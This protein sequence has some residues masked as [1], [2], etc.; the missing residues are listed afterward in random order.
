[1]QCTHMRNQGSSTH[2]SVLICSVDYLKDNTIKSHGIAGFFNSPHL[3]KSKLLF[4][5]DVN[6]HNSITWPS[7]I[8]SNSSHHLTE[9]CGNRLLICHWRQASNIHSPSMPSSL[10]SH[11]L[12][13]HVGKATKLCTTKGE[14]PWKDPW[15]GLRHPRNLARHCTWNNRCTWGC[16]IKPTCPLASP[17]T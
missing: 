4:L 17:V 2:Q 13:W 8:C 10:L 5:I 12:C 15:H 1:M 6:I 16:H 7:S 11:C 14:H 9:I 3:H